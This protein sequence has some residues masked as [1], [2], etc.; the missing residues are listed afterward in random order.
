ML[1]GAGHLLTEDTEEAEALNAAFVSAFTGRTCLQEFEV[2]KMSRKVWRKE[3]FPQQ[4]WIRLRE[5]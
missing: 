2:L 1:S 3:E 4:S 5:H